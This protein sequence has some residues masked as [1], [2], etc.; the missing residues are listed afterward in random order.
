MAACN[1]L[2][3]RKP[4]PGQEAQNSGRWS[5]ETRPGGM[6]GRSIPERFGCPQRS[7]CLAALLYIPSPCLSR[8][9]CFRAVATFYGDPWAVFCRPKSRQEWRLQ[10]G[11]P[12]PQIHRIWLC[13]AFAAV[14][15]DEVLVDRAAA[16]EAFVDA[17]PV[18]DVVL[19][20]APAEVD[21]FAPEQG[22]EIEPPQEGR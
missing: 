5:Q 1:T 8:L 21:F 6:H 3:R 4:L 14:V 16:V 7:S 20:H 18:V 15:V 12:A 10:A 22:G 17:V 2:S 9:Y 19:I 11:L 13:G